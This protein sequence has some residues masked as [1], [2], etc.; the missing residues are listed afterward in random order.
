MN[1]GDELYHTSAGRMVIT[2]ITEHGIVADIILGNRVGYSFPMSDFGNTIFF[3]KAHENMQ[4]TFRV[5]PDEYFD[6]VQEKEAERQKVAE[7][8]ALKR[9]DQENRKREMEMA[10]VRRKHVN[11]G[12]KKT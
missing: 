11:D 10:Q 8:E 5:R 4:G 3:A 1:V 12:Q 2:A 7:Q 9:E 6:F